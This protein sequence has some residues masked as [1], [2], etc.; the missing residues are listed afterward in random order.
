MKPC[1]VYVCLF[2]SPSPG[3]GD[4]IVERS[5]RS[6]SISSN[7]YS[8]AKTNPPHPHHL[9]PSNPNLPTSPPHQYSHLRSRS[10][11]QVYPQHAVQLAQAQRPVTM[12][13]LDDDSNSIVVVQRQKSSPANGHMGSGYSHVTPSERHVLHRLESAPVINA[14]SP[15]PPDNT[16]GNARVSNESRVRPDSLSGV[17]DDL[18]K[19]TQELDCI[20]T[21]MW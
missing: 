2:V 3:S 10:G 13:R 6:S 16:D 1:H 18:T 20:F 21:G 12:T 19:M 5:M 11:P 17:L 9:P 7:G 8:Y 15:A 14:N 4:G